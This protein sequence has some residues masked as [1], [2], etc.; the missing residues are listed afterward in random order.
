MD[1]VFHAQAHPQ[2]EVGNLHQTVSVIAA[3]LVT[4]AADQHTLVAQGVAVIKEIVQPQYEFSISEEE[5]QTLMGTRMPM[6]DRFFRDV[7]F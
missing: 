1:L 4:L 3:I 2:V 6:D 5:W 7:Q